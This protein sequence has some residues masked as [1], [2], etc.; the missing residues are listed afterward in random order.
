MF[1]EWKTQYIK[2][3]NSLQIAQY[4]KNNTNKNSSSIFYK[5]RQTDLKFIGEGK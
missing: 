5:H 1:M 2:D 3:V 4:F